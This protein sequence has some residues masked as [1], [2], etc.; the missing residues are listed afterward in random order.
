MNSTKKRKDMMIYP[1]DKFKKIWNINMIVIL[2]SVGLFT[3]FRVCFV[4]S[5]TVVWEVVD[6]IY[7]FIFLVDMAVNFLAVYID[8]D[9]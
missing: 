7:D 9:N 5:D 6:Y 8:K 2:L 3:P 1:D 4:E